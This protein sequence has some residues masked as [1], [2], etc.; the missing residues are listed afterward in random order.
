LADVGKGLVSFVCQQCK[1]YRKLAVPSN[2][3][4]QR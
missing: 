3:T 1:V 4:G 2:L